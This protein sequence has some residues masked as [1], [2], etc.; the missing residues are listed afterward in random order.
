MPLLT[1]AKLFRLLDSRVGSFIDQLSQAFHIAVSREG[2]FV[3]DHFGDGCGKTCYWNG[4]GYYGESFTCGETYPSGNTFYCS[5]TCYCTLGSTTRVFISYSWQDRDLVDRMTAALARSDITYLRDMNVVGAFDDIQSFMEDAGAA[6]F[7]VAILSPAYLQSRNCMYELQQVMTSAVNIRLVPLIEQ[8]V[9]EAGPRDAVRF[10]QARAGEINRA[11]TAL[12]PDGTASLQQERQFVSASIAALSDL[13][14]G[15]HATPLPTIG[16]LVGQDFQGIVRMIRRTVGQHAEPRHTI[17][18]T[19]TREK[20]APTAIPEAPT[21]DSTRH[22]A[23]L[24]T[25]SNER[26]PRALAD[27]MRRELAADFQVYGNDQ[28]AF[29]TFQALALP[30]SKKVLLALLDGPLLLDASTAWQVIGTSGQHSAH[31]ISIITDA[32][33]F[34]PMSEVSFIAYWQRQARRAGG[35]FGERA[36]FIR[37][38]VGEFIASARSKLTPDIDAMKQSHYAILKEIIRR[39]IAASS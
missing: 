10:W 6:R 23:V 4:G 22:L 21:D 15:L 16:D 20:L 3:N 19:A 28:A 32:T 39:K 26:L 35:A 13:F 34:A 36:H 24:I 12:E 17:T 25:S 9:I 31:V 2:N 30:P 7:F 14:E 38:H 33:L 8:A 1:D 29:D 37:D 18:D 5:D 11:L 27:D